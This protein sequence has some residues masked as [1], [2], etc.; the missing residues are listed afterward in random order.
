MYDTRQCFYV[1]R[2]GISVG[3]D[4]M[5]NPKDTLLKIADSKQRRAYWHGKE[6]VRYSYGNY[7]SLDQ[8]F[9]PCYSRLSIG[10]YTS[11]NCLST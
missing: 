8:M 3:S 1:V 7:M 2:N 9:N 10:L 4:S 5:Q 11:Q 6:S